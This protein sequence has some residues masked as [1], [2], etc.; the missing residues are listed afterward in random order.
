M[1]PKGPEKKTK[2]EEEKKLE[3]DKKKVG[4]RKRKRLPK[5]KNKT[6]RKKNRSKPTKQAPLFPLF[7]PHPP[8]LCPQKKILIAKQGK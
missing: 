5:P 8:R 2:R 4:G 7:L 6:V 3:S 1:H